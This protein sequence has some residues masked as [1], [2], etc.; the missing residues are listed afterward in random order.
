VTVG[1]Q[2]GILQFYDTIPNLIGNFSA[3]SASIEC[4][5]VS[6]NQSFI[7]SGSADSTV[8]IWNV[9]GGRVSYVRSY[10]S[11]TASV[12]SIDFYDDNY[13]IS[14]S[15]DNTIHVWDINTGQI[16]NII[17][18]NFNGP[19]W[20]L[21]MISSQNYLAS[22]HANGSI[23]IWN[24]LIYFGDS[25]AMHTLSSHTNVVFDLELIES[26]QML[27]SASWDST[28]AL[29]NLNNFT[30]IHVLQGHTNKVM[31]LLP[32]TYG[33]YVNILFSVS[34]DNSIVVWNLDTYSALTQWSNVSAGSYRAF[35]PLNETIVLSG[36]QADQTL[37]VWSLS[38][39]YSSI[40]ISSYNIGI[41]INTLA[42]AKC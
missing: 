39:P 32:I 33:S 3:H 14:S 41:N 22:G 16:I 29:W 36:S 12:E 27:V 13:V 21:K 35:E 17:Q 6:S 42:V 30:L 10:T 11:H 18:T 25:V 34:S 38:A 31:A 40:Q 9:N 20:S 26:R 28:I 19:V 37:R 5:K 23:V 1:S 8:K 24:N 4:L 15:L 2:E 7:L